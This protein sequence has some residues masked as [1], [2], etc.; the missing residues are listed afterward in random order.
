MLRESFSDALTIAVAA[1][2]LLSTSTAA[3]Q[4]V[5]HYYLD[6]R[7]VTEISKYRSCAGHHYGY[8]EMMIGLGLYEVE[9]DPTETNRSMKH[10]FSPLQSFREN[11]S[12]NTLELHA[13]FDG[14]IYRVTAEGHESGYVNKQVWIQSK[15]SPDTFAILFHVN[16]LDVFPDYW[17]DY[18]PEFWQHHGADDTDYERLAVSS[19]E[20]IGYA[21][22]RGTISDIA[23]L[24]KVSSAEYHYLSY[25][26]EAVMTESVFALHQQRGLDS[27]DDVIVSREFRNANPLPADCWGGRRDEDWVRLTKAGNDDEGVTGESSDEV[28]RVSL[29]EP[30]N[31][32]IHTGVGNLRGW[33]IGEAGIE[34]VEIWI[35]DVYA[36]DVPYG[37]SRGDVANAFPDVSGSGESGYSMA[38]AYS[39]LSAG[40]HTAKAVAYNA[41]GLVAESS[42]SFS[43]EKFE[44]SFITDPNAVDLTNASCS[45]SG[46]EVSI[47]DA[48]VSGDPLDM[49]LKWRTAEQGFEI[50]EIHGSGTATAMR[51]QRQATSVRD[52]VANAESS[53]STLQVTLEEPVNAEIHSGVGNLRGWAVASEGVEKI[54]IFIDGDYAFDAPYGGARGD[55]GAA[56][57][58]ISNSTESGFSLAFTYSNLTAGTHTMEAVARTADGA[59]ERS[60]VTFEVVKFAQNFISDSQ[61]VNLDAAGCAT[62]GDEISITGAAVAGETYDIV[63]DWRTAEQGF[64]IVQIRS[65]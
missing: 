10:Y 57:P 38:F 51:V 56:F 14:T 18:P 9:T 22:L 29:E 11:G 54:E 45:L 53:G 28:F 35:D 58:D 23:I 41:A 1:A 65:P 33:A 40:D 36:F 61:A 3:S 48:V 42:A 63:L 20:V 47:T 8:D 49:L 59:D 2:V 60:A 64:E 4:V 24:K 21:D 13:P 52:A 37:G 31:G 44:E 19:G 27:R 62:K 16:L 39:N 15:T 50:I 25:F 30:I 43:I 32:Q 6:P 17:N 55:V 46:D 34:K 26:D 12:N 7:N 5:D